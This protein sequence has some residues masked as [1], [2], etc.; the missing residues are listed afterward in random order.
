MSNEASTPASASRNRP[1][2]SSAL[3]LLDPTVP[4]LRRR[5][6]RSPLA[7]PV[8]VGVVRRPRNDSGPLVSFV[9]SAA[10]VLALS[11]TRDVAGA[12]G[13]PTWAGWVAGIAALV[14]AA[15]VLGWTAEWLS[16]R[17][18]AGRPPSRGAPGPGRP[19]A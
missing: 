19:S 1:I 7:R 12:L 13:W 10:S 17:R 11:V 4:H 16:L 9:V 18:G 15:L 14:V 5:T 6:E 8:S 3:P 2:T